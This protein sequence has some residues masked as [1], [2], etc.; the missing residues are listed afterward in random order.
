MAALYGYPFAVVLFYFVGLFL[1]FLDEDP[2][3]VE[4]SALLR[5]L[6]LLL[7][8]IIVTECMADQALIK[9]PKC[10]SF[11]DPPYPQDENCEFSIL[12]FNPSFPIVLKQPRD[13]HHTEL[14]PFVDAVVERVH[15]LPFVALSR[16][17]LRKL[18]NFVV[19]LLYDC[20]DLFPR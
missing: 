18:P 19:D 6:I 9:H 17:F 5:G 3:G 4:V 13:I 2:P 20:T 12:E 1:I 8:E 14:I 10:V 15:E 7:Q 11:Q 16:Q